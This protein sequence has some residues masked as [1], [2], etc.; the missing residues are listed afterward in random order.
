MDLIL[1]KDFNLK[2]TLECGQFFRFK[3]INDWYFVN[4]R[5][6]LFKLKQ[7]KNKIYYKFAECNGDFDKKE[8]LISFFRLDE[9]YED[10]ARNISKDKHVKKAVSM[11]KGLRLIKQDPWECAISYICSSAANIPKIQMNIELLSRAFGKKIVLDGFESYT[12][13]EPGSM[14]NI[15]KIKKC[16]VGFRAEF[17]FEA[18][19]KLTK[20]DNLKNMDYETARKEL[21]KIKGIGEKVADCVCLFSLGKNEAFPVDTWVNKIMNKLYLKNEKNRKRISSFAR[22]YFGKNAGYAQ[23]YLFY[24][25]REGK[26]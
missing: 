1:V 5:D 19:K 17:I 20:I 18:N 13:P 10:I 23:E 16:R 2:H 8:F 15:R 22:E 26:Q 21:M 24:A 3:K 14:N 4:S 12:F 7:D 6:K 9:D 25:I 11:F